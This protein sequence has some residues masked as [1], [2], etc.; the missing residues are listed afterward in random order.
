MSRLYF[1]LV[2]GVDTL[3]D[4][5]GVEIAADEVAGRALTEARALI[6]DEALLGRIDLRQRIEVKDGEGAVLHCLPFAAAVE[7]IPPG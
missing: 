4:Q 5:D 7:I 1:H 2:D 6:A 3:I